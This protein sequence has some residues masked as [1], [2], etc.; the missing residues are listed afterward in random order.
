M[1]IHV[2]RS[3]LE[4]YLLSPYKQTNKIFSR[5]LQAGKRPNF[6]T[7]SVGS[8]VMLGVHAGKGKTTLA[9]RGGRG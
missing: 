3:S 5:L 7:N 9:I 1:K 2:K 8:P 6:I 4:S